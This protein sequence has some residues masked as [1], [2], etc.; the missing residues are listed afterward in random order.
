MIQS[1]IIYLVQKFRPDLE[2]TSKEVDTLR[3]HFKSKVH[4]LHLSKINN[5]KIKKN[6]LSYHFLFYPLYAP[7]LYLATRLKIIHIYTTL[8]DRPYLPLFSG[9]RTVLTST[10]YFTASRLHS[11]RRY[12]RKVQKIVVESPLQTKELLRLGLPEKQID[13]IYPSVDLNAFS[14]QKPEGKF[15][16]LNASCP[17]RVS[18]LEKRGIFLLMEA[19]SQLTDTTIDVLWRIGEYQKFRQMTKGKEFNCLRVQEHIAE[20][21]NE[22]YA[23]HHCTIIPYTQFDELLKLIPNS[24]MESLAAGKPILVSSQTGIAEIVKKEHCG[25]VFEPTAEKLLEAIQT[26]KENYTHYQQNCR[27]TAEK[28]FSQEEFLKKYEQIYAQIK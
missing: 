1:E 25:I 6:L 18:D 14:Y 8:R 24:A 5:F 15:K 19:D 22:I 4:D 23:A 27:K 10:N 3:R 11:W 2:G 12:L 28:Y 21:M 17:S 13:I 7:F 20:N 26:L 9:P 16:I